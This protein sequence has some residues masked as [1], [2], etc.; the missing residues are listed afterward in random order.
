M[1]LTPEERQIL[2]VLENALSVSDYTDT[3]DIWARSQKSSRV[4]EGLRDVLS[5]AT[6]LMVTH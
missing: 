2:E 5:I 4:F 6:G 1:R 3:V